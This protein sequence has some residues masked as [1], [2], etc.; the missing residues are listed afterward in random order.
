MIAE[1]RKPKIAMARDEEVQKNVEANTV[2]WVGPT[3]LEKQER[4][5]GSI[6]CSGVR[7]LKQARGQLQATCTSGRRQFGACQ[8]VQGSEFWWWYGAWK[9]QETC[10]P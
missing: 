2:N 10:G 1:I 8:P 6:P 4:A 3:K 5:K 7:G 9:E